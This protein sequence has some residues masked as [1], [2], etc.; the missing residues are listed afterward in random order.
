[1]DALQFIKEWDRM[2]NTIDASMG[3][4]E[5]VWGKQRSWIGTCQEDVYRDPEKAIS[6]LQTWIANNPRKTILQ[7]VLEK[8]PNTQLD[9]DIPR[10]C[11]HYLGYEKYK[12]DNPDLCIASECRKCWN[13]PLEE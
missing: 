5:C 8:Y 2:C 13:R 3:C 1:M 6:V 7:D 10:F 11:P 12:S 4:K 9:N